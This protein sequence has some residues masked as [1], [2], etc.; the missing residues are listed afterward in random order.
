MIIRGW[1]AFVAV[2]MGT[3][4]VGAVVFFVADV[5]PGLSPEAASG[6]LPGWAV[7][8]QVGHTVAT[9]TAKTK[10]GDAAR[11]VVAMDRFAASHGF[12]RDQ[13][14]AVGVRAA[15]PDRINVSYSSERAFLSFVTKPGSAELAVETEP[16]RNDDL[17]ELVR[18]VKVVLEPFGFAQATR[19]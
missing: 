19:T 9:F 16:G 7:S 12:V 17:A 11:I 3:G 10:V 13:D 2:V 5:L 4:V 14:Q 15:D 6:L 18:D 8:A 1:R